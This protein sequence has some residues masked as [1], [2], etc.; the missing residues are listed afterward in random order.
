MATSPRKEERKK[1][2]SGSIRTFVPLLSRPTVRVVKFKWNIIQKYKENQL[3]VWSNSCQNATNFNYVSSVRT[4][5]QNRTVSIKYE[6]TGLNC[7]DGLRT[8]FG[9]GSFRVVFDFV[10]AEFRS[11]SININPKYAIITR[12]Q[13]SLQH[14][15]LKAKGTEPTMYRI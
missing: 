13:I 12:L 4:N 5:V 11:A 14:S 8:M 15:L 10:A 7:A 3:D 1:S 6:Q 9:F 2:E